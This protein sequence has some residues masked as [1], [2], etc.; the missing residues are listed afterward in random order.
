M[1]SISTNNDLVGS[2]YVNNLN[3]TNQASN[4]PFNPN[5]ND[6]YNIGDGFKNQKNNELANPT[7]SCYLGFQPISNNQIQ[8]LQSN[9]FFKI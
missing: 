4:F 8:N 6:L 9:F 1:N 2:F 7:D 3:S 5:A